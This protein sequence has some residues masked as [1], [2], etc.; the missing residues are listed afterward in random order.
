M[1]HS[2]AP[3][4]FRLP[5]TPNRTATV[6]YD[7][8]YHWLKGVNKQKK[9]PK[10]NPS[11]FIFSL[12]TM[13]Q[14]LPCSHWFIAAR[15]PSSWLMSL[16]REDSI[17]WFYNNQQLDRLEDGA[18]PGRQSKSISECAHVIK[19]LVIRG[20]TQSISCCVTIQTNMF[21]VIV[22][23]GNKWRWIHSKWFFSFYTAALQTNNKIWT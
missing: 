3:F 18:L 19:A 6:I 17:C 13:K 8:D 15:T 10:Q 7:A 21:V 14:A 2:T 4:C 1:L 23:N 5:P 20:V 9:K 12:V 11:V 22:I 16:P